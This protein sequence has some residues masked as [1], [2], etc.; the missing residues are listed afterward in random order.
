MWLKANIGLVLVVLLGSCGVN[1]AEIGQ[2]MK[3]TN[4]IHSQ[5]RV[6]NDTVMGGISSSSWQVSNR[7]EGTFSGHVSLENYGGFA[8][9]R[10]A[11]TPGYFGS[12][13]HIRVRIK[14]DGKVYKFCVY[15]HTAGPSIGY[16]TSIQTTG[17]WQT[18]SLPLNEFQAKWRGRLVGDAPPAQ[19][20][21][22]AAVGFMISD[23]QAGP[24]TLMVATIEP[25]P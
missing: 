14:G 15:T 12:A 4:A 22:V 21:D 24:F 17:E 10:G 16:Q 11:V 7:E 2:S 9:V 19:A 6:V 18:V 13:T 8:S 1:P 3:N 25:T 23:K 20:T 5:W